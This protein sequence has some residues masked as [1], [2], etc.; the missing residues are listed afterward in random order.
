[1]SRKRYKG[2][3]SGPFVPLLKDTLKTPA[4]KALSHGARSLYVLLKWRYN[5]NLTNAVYLSTRDAEKELGRG[6]E[7]RNVMRWFREL[8]YYGFIVKVQLA[9]HGANGH[10]KAPHWRLTDVKHLRKEPTR[11][12]LRW[13]GRLFDEP[14]RARRYPPKNRSRGVNVPST[15]VPTSPP[16]VPKRKAQNGTSGGNVPSISANGTGTH[17][18]SITSQPLGGA[19]MRPGWHLAPA[20]GGLWGDHSNNGLA[21]AGSSR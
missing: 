9:H 19:A 18:P 21:A 11:E 2:K 14:K 15:P 3:I 20:A 16:L 12:F 1:M 4:W 5:N 8:E 13:D 17:V 10:G 7:R 6:G